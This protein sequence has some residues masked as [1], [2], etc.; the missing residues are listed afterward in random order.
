MELGLGVLL[1]SAQRWQDHFAESTVVGLP[2]VALAE[3]LLLGQGRCTLAIR[4]RSSSHIGE[5][6]LLVNIA[7]EGLDQPCNLDL[8]TDLSQL[9]LAD[10]EIDGGCGTRARK[11]QRVVLI[12][13][14][15]ALNDGSGLLPNEYSL[16]ATSR[17]HRVRVCVQRH[18]MTGYVVL[19]EAEGLA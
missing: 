19:D 17:L 10:E 12:R 7:L 9:E 14:A 3:V 8:L 6:L 18:H 13:V 4:V 2:P 1:V 11:D 16:L 5:H 15:D